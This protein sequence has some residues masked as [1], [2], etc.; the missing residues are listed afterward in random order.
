MNKNVREGKGMLF[1]N[2]NTLRE[3]WFNNGSLNGLGRSINNEG[4]VYIGSFKNGKIHG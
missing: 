1:N 3:G 4:N 2:S